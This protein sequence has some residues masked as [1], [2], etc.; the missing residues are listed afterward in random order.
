VFSDYRAEDK[1]RALG[2]SVDVIRD[3]TAT[4]VARLKP[5]PY[6]F[7]RVAELLEVSPSRC[8]IIGDRDDRDGAAAKRAGFVFLKKTSGRRPPAQY[9]FNSYHDLVNELGVCSR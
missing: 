5:N 7:L 4:D 3:A 8:L 6:G 9:Q 1:L 2:L